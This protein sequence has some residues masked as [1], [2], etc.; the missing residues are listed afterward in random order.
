M[1]NSPVFSCFKNNILSNVERY[2][3]IRFQDVLNV[4]WSASLLKIVI[5]ILTSKSIWKLGTMISY[6]YE[7]MNFTYSVYFQT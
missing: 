4:N 1:K 7:F 6:V 3:D 5:N 2:L